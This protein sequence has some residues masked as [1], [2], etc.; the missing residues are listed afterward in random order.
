MVCGPE[1]FIDQPLQKHALETSG[2]DAAFIARRNL[3]YVEV[4][5]ERP[6]ETIEI[7]RW[8]IGWYRTIFHKESVAFSAGGLG[9]WSR[10]LQ[11]S[12]GRAAGRSPRMH[13]P[14][15]ER[16]EVA[17]PYAIGAIGHAQDRLSLEHVKTF[18]VR[19]NVGHQRS[20]R[21]ELVNTQAR[22]N[23]VGRVVD[24]RCVTVAIAVPVVRGM[25]RKRGPVE[26]P[27]VM[28]ELTPLVLW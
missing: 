9:L 16:S 21:R 27:E 22:M 11:P 3:A 12:H 2:H 26:V 10:H 24:Q 7:Q 1:F 6:V 5:K 4:A 28:H 20:T 17:R 13:R 8:R 19:V 23:R 15:L 25:M 14:H 18:F